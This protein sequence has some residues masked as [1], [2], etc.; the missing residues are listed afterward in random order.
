MVE[1]LADVIHGLLLLDNILLLLSLALA[2]LNSAHSEKS[3]FGV[4][5]KLTPL[6]WLEINAF[7]KAGRQKNRGHGVRRIQMETIEVFERARELL[8]EE[9]KQERMADEKHLA[10][11]ETLSCSLE[12]KALDNLRQPTTYDYFCP[13]VK[14]ARVKHQFGELKA[15]VDNYIADLRKRMDDRK[16]TFTKVCAKVR[17]FL[18]HKDDSE[19]LSTALDR[20]LLMDD[21][22]KIRVRINRDLPPGTYSTKDFTRKYTVKHETELKRAMVESKRKRPDLWMLLPKLLELKQQMRVAM[23]GDA[24]PKEESDDD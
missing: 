18:K 17:E 22:K 7:L 3:I 5:V 6:P 12:C 11:M 1:S 8:T 24:P 14:L 13:L 15:P 21:G 4:N 23:N 20:L 9:V 10:E 19:V 16:V 2:H